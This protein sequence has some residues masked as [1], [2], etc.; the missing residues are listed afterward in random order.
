MR[1]TANEREAILS[2]ARDVFGP[3]CTVRLFGSRVDDARSGG[4]I[5]LHV[6]A[7]PAAAT[8]ANEIAFT[9]TVQENIGE[10]RVDVILRPQRFVPRAIDNIAM[11]AG[12]IL[13]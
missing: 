1:L 8:L 2:S 10:Q 13:S 12:V 6:I 11:R 7:E 9:L 4:D 3:H 5:D